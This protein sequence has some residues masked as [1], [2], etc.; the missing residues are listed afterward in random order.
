MA[1][2]R[3]PLVALLTDF[4]TRDPYVAAMKLVIADRC[5]AEILDLGHDIGRHDVMEAAVFLRFALRTFDARRRTVVVAVVDPGV[6]SSRRIVAA[7]R[8]ELI[9]LAPDNGLL[10]L[11]IGPG[12][13]TRSVE[14]AALFLPGGASTF[15]G[16]DRF[17]P[18]AAALA[19][20]AGV[21]SLGPALAID[22]LVALPYAPP[23]IGVNE[24][25]GTILSIDRFGNGVTDVDAS[26]LGD[27][28]QWRAYAGERAI[29]ACARTYAEMEGVADPFLIAGSGGTV[30]ISVSGGSAADVLQ[31]SRLQAVRF[32]RVNRVDG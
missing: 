11:S 32:V 28:G 19:A 7:A 12:W 10:S 15:H 18:V 14:R 4:G 13:Q 21:D 5:E 3:K 16:R 25:T 8:G 17:A 23:H 2:S 30:E 26:V 20:G 27:L 22:E 24:V 29:D 1:G 9:L 31:L 6:G